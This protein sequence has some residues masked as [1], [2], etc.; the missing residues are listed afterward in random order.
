MKFKPILKERIWGG[1]KLRTRLNK[2]TGTLKQTGESWE[3]SG[4]EGDLSL[5]SNGYL[6]GNNLKE[7]IEV[8]MGELVGDR[9]F[10]RFGLEFP[11]LIKFIDA[12][13]VLSVQ[14]HPGDEL[15][16]ERHQC[17]GKTEMWYILDAEPGS[18]I[19]TGFNRE[20]DRDTYLSKLEKG[21][22]REILNTE[23][24]TAGDV[25]DI[26]AGRV[27]ATGPGILLAEIQQSSDVTYR[28][29]DWDRVDKQGRSRELHTA[30]ALDAIDFKRYDHYKIHPGSSLNAPVLLTSNPYFRV[31]RY[32][33]DRD[34]E[35]DFNELD[36]FLVYLCLEGNGHILYA[37]G[38]E[39]FST[40]D[41]L[42]VPASLEQ[43]VLSPS[44]STTLLEV[45]LP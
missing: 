43:V 19:Y 34:Y 16:A 10:D 20:M 23:N 8:Y 15:A 3:I 41:T 38:Q 14:V 33:I 22:I 45:H 44:P 32:H 25:F 37:D 39:S 13:E 2:D 7:L 36:S 5:V 6:Q 31:S 1:E 42:L 29:Y 35:R 21:K 18:L 11:L 4:L 30:Q 12:R 28:I 9:V 26:P 24:V 40:G 27:H 17:F